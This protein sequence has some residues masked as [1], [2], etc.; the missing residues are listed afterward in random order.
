LG[1]A[2]IAELVIKMRG[3]QL[4]IALHGGIRRRLSLALASDVRIAGES[5]R[6]RG[7]HPHRFARDIGASS[8]PRRTS[9]LRRAGAA[10]HR[11][12]HRARA[13]ATPGRA[14]CPTPAESGPRGAADI[15][16]TRRW[17]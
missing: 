2:P 4:F 5:A 7:L 6:E 13:L 15:L 17:A 11:R 1:A 14:S 12:L 10:A 8:T 9:A 3:S 16:R